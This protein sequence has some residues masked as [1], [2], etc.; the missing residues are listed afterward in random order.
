MLVTNA[1]MELARRFTVVCRIIRLI[2][3]DYVESTVRGKNTR[4][5]L[6]D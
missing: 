3:I 4:G 5:V 6:E 1:A 2:A